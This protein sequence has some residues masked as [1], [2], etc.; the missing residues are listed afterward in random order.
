MLISSNQTLIFSEFFEELL[1]FLS[2]FFILLRFFGD[3]V[4]RSD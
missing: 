2:A 1:N 4:E 3:Y